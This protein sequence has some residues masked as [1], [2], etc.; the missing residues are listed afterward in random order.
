MTVV[1]NG[2]IRSGKPWAS[3][4]ADSPGCDLALPFGQLWH[5]HKITVPREY[6]AVLI[7]FSL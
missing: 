7:Y 6:S 4:S 5:V 2:G 3:T 1:R